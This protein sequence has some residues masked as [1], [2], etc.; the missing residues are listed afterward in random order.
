MQP[1]KTLNEKPIAQAHFE[2]AIQ[3]KKNFPSLKK[4]KKKNLS[5]NIP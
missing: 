4:S 3:A 1:F 2:R 5:T